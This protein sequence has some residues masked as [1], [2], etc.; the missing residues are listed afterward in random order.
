[1]CRNYC[2]EKWLA[3]EIT[4]VLPQFIK[5]GTRKNLQEETCTKEERFNWPFRTKLERLGWALLCVLIIDLD[6]KDKF[7]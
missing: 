3:E 7:N 6:I 5:K 4:N 1:M 2:R